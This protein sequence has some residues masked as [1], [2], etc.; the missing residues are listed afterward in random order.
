MTVTGSTPQQNVVKNKVAQT[1]SVEDAKKAMSIDWMSMNDL[2]QAIPPP[3]TE[4]IGARLMAW[5]IE[6][7]RLKKDEC[8]SAEAA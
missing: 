5:L 2:S 7:G 6:S 1:Y 8:V 3:F 4:W